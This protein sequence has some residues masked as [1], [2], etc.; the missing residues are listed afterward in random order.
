VSPWASIF[1]YCEQEW[2]YQHKG[3]MLLRVVDDGIFRD[4]EIK[5]G[6]LLLLPGALRALARRFSF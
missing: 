2:F 3:D 4:I 1:F 5:E 6:Q